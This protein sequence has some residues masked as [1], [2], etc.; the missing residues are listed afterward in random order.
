MSVTDLEKIDGAGLDNK[1]PNRLNLMIADD[2]DWVE[3]D[4]HLEILADK[5]NNY[6]NYIKSRQYLSN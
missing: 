4:I 5:L 3:S 2:L 1:V 6:Y